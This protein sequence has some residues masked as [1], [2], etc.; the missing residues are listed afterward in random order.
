MPGK[1]KSSPWLP[2]DYWGA[3]IAMEVSTMQYNKYE[4][5]LTCSNKEAKTT[6]VV[7]LVTFINT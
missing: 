3:G 2:I 1:Y 6:V 7:T 5:K 4:L